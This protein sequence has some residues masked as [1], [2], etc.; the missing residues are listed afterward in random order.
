VGEGAVLRGARGRARSAWRASRSPRRE[1]EIRQ[2]HQL[3][4]ERRFAEQPGLLLQCP[5]HDAEL[6]LLFFD[7]RDGSP[8]LLPGNPALLAR[9][10]LAVGESCSV[11][12]GFATVAGPD[13]ER[14][15]D[16]DAFRAGKISITPM[17]GAMTAGA[18]GYALTG[19]VLKRLQP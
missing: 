5:P 18:A 8:P 11:G 19:A 15:A 4:P 6:A 12:V 17:D 3:V 9:D 14:D 13:A 10:V 7:R 2:L 16:T 1:V